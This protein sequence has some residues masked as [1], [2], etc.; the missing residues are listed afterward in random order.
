MIIRLQ[1]K[2]GGFPFKIQL[3][4][5]APQ[6][7]RG[8]RAMKFYNQFYTGKNLHEEHWDITVTAISGL[9]CIQLIVTTVMK[10]TW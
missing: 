6:G 9:V 7:R 10:A 1:G 4:M 8:G 3:K 5:M 2:A